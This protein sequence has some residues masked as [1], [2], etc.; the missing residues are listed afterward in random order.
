MEIPTLRNGVLTIYKGICGRQVG[1]RVKSV[2]QEMDSIVLTVHD[3]V[4]LVDL[5]E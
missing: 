3:L 4:G 5:E 2:N 1:N